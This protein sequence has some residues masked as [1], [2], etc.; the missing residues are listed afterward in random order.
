MMSIFK[1]ADVT[2]RCPGCRDPL[3]FNVDHEEGNCRAKCENCGHKFQAHI[4]I[5]IDSFVHIEK[6][7]KDE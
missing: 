3:V 5:E 7:K 2:V 1:F 4:T 6:D